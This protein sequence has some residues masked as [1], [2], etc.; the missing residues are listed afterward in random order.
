MDPG[1]V[2]ILD[3]SKPDFV[4]PKD[5]NFILEEIGITRDDYYEALKISTDNDFQIHFMREPTCFVNN[6]FNEGLIAWKA[7]IV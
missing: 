5:I 1:K 2:N 4:E 7:N 6:Y 3:P